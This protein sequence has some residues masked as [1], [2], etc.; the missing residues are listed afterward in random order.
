MDFPG[1]TTV[2]QV[3]LPATAEQYIHRLGRTA[4][5]G[6][7]GSGILILCEWETFFLKKREISALPLAAH[8]NAKTSLSL[9]SPALAT[10][11]IDSAEAMSTVSDEVKAQAYSASL[12][13]YKGFIR[14]AFGT[15]SNL[16][17]VS[18]FSN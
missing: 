18:T 2:I 8:P 12:G 6:A 13:Y 3:G 10:A 11:R 1:V 5:A 14:D 16:V 9:T 15:A 4:R 17:Q 7:A